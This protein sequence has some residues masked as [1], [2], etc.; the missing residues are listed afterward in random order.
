MC[1]EA[2]TLYLLLDESVFVGSGKVAPRVVVD[3]TESDEVVGTVSL[4]AVFGVE[5]IHA[6]FRDDLTPWMNARSEVGL[7][8][9]VILA[10]CETEILL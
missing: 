5:P 2:D 3:Y 8:L 9:R 7:S 6:T 1:K 10:Q 4:S